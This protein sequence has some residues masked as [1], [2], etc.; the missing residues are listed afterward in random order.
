MIWR[1]SDTILTI[2]V[3]EY[4]T[5]VRGLFL[6]SILESPVGTLKFY[7]WICIYESVFSL[8]LPIMVAERGCH[9]DD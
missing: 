1:D 3:F 8:I 7:F 9:K 4:F 5:F 2:Y 6:I